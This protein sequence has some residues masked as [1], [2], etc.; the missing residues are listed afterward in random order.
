MRDV[1]LYY[2]LIESHIPAW[3]STGTEIGDFEWPR[4]A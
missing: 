4:K 2:L 1:N 3:L